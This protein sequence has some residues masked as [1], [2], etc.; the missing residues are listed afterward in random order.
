MGAGG[1]ISGLCLSL[2]I[3]DKSRCY[4]TGGGGGRAEGFFQ[5]RVGGGGVH[6]V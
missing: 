5:G 2:F 6:M 3:I 4:R 1:L